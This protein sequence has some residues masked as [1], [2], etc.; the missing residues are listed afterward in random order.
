MNTDLTIDALM[1]ELKLSD[2]QLNTSIDESDLFH[3]ARCFEN[4]DDYVEKFGLSPA[5]QTEVEDKCSLRGVVAGIKKAL[6]FWRRKN[7]L[8]AT[9]RTLLDIVL[10]LKKG[11]VAVRICQY[12]ADKCECLTMCNN[13]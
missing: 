2:G 13:L 4:A 12:L 10:S 9:F 3:L 1:R 5:Q 11:D 8:L 6:K 7:P